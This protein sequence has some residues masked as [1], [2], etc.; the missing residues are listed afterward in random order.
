MYFCQSLLKI[1]MQKN[2]LIKVEEEF[3]LKYKIKIYLIKN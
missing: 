2:Y 1:E 3:N